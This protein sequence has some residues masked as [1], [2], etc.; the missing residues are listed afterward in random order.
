MQNETLPVC[1][2]CGKAPKQADAA[3]CPYC[4]APMDQRSAAPVPEGA[5][6]LLDEAAKQ[7]D[8]KK[9]YELLK[10][11]SASTPIAWRWRRSCCFWAACMSAT[12]ARWIF[13]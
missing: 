12:P 6:R 1:P 4:G 3:F 10:T 8:P 2:R 7:P 13:P 11:P 5:Q 9:K